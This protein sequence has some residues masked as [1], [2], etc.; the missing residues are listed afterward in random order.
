MS[1]EEKVIY[2][3]KGM[4]GI[5]GIPTDEEFL[6]EFEFRLQALKQG[7]TLPIDNIIARTY[8]QDEGK[9]LTLSILE[10]YISH[11]QTTID[12]GENDDI[13][14]LKEVEKAIKWV[15]DCGSNDAGVTLEFIDYSYEVWNI[16]NNSMI[17]S[18]K[19]EETAEVYMTVLASLESEYEIRK[20]CCC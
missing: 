18:C 20:I 13:E 11:C 8:S 15:K 7:Q 2:I 6:N 17:K 16:T 5:G 12:M 1:I 3:I 9:K 14:N 4:E 19:Y 10:Q